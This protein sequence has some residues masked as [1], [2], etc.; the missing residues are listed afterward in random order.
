MRP[1]VSFGNMGLNEQIVGVGAPISS[2]ITSTVNR[3]FGS[4]T[5]GQS[6]PCLSIQ[7]L[8]GGSCNQISP[9]AA[10]CICT[11]KFFG[12]KCE[13][14]LLTFLKFIFYISS[15]KQTL[16]IFFKSVNLFG[17]LLLIYVLLILFTNANSFLLFAWLFFD[18]GY[19]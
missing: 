14:G 5:V 10:F 2:G 3:S 17:F 11:S 4:Q 8:N 1:Q 18:T 16:H 15:Q 7:C 13:I 19:K 6:S 12:E 9:T